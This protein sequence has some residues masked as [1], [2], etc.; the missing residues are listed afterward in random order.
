M[1][2]GIVLFKK[3]FKASVYIFMQLLIL[4]LALL[5]GEAWS[6]EYNVIPRFLFRLP[7]T[8]LTDEVFLQTLYT[9]ITIGLIFYTIS[10]VV[11]SSVNFKNY[12]RTMKE[13]YTTLTSFTFSMLYIFLLLTF[14]SVQISLPHQAFYISFCF[15]LLNKYSISSTEH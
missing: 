8:P 9:L 14:F 6:S 7:A 10:T 13:L 1:L 12:K 3:I 2:E 11:F 5:L 4:V 15:L